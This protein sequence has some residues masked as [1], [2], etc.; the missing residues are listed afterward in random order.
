MPYQFRGSVFLFLAIRAT[1]FVVILGFFVIFFG[2]MPPKSRA[3]TRLMPHN[4]SP[5]KSG[6]ERS[7]KEPDAVETRPVEDRSG[8]LRSSR[9]HSR[10]P[11]RKRRSVVPDSPEAERTPAWAKKLLKEHNKSEKRLERFERELKARPRS[12]KPGQAKSPQPEFKYKRNKVQYELNAK[13]L[14]KL[15][16]AADPSVRKNVPR[17]WTKVRSFYWRE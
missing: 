7:R 16:E 8:S 4:H 12:D 3:P 5:E 10:S 13:V 15:E 2:N 17:R 11:S 9:H 1:A 6:K 14:E